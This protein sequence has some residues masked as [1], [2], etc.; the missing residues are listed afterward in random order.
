M[1]FPTLTKNPTIYNWS[2]EMA[3]DP[4]IRNEKEGGYVQ[5]RARFTRTPWTWKLLYPAIPTADKVL[6]VAH[7]KAM[8]G[9]AESFTWINIDD[10]ATYTVRYKGKIS[11]KP[12]IYGTYWYVEITL[13]EV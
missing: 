6:I 2:E 3:L 12:L 8:K 9:G 11:Y 13:E 1:A 5:T 7:E 4:V 10:S